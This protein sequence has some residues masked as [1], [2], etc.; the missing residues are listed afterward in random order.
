MTKKK[1]KGR[2]KFWEIDEIFREMLTFFRETPKKGREK[3]K[4]L[5]KI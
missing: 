4:I 3:I 2:Q 5:G 1:K